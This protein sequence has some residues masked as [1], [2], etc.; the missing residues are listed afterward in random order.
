MP[1]KLCSHSYFLTPRSYQ[2]NYPLFVFLPGMD[3]TG[4]E[5]MYIQ[6][7]GLEAAFDVRCFVIPP[8]DL[9]SWDEMTDELASLTQIELKKVPRSSVYLCAE[10]F[11]CCLGIKVLERFPQLFTK[12]I[13]I[14]S[15]SS[16]HRVP[17]L[18]LG[19]RLF[20]YTPN[21]FYKISSFISL[22]CLA[23]LNR[24]SPAAKKALLNS[25]R[26]APKATA[27]QRLTLMREFEM[28]EMKLTQITQP[29]LLIAS[30]ND[31]LLPSEA[32]AIRL[33]NIFPNFQ[34]IN[35]PHSGHACLVEKDVNIYQI[36]MSV[37][38]IFM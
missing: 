37:N 1:S 21:F 18:N 36:L 3:E 25:T 30:K 19:S 17:W 13:L 26:S 34:I 20:P 22:P 29:V 15:A 5:L 32:E 14:N 31:R 11:G 33:S 9:T 7:A 6:T 10:S 35:L 28:N 38:F 24:I 4:K 23:N 12:I 16:F 2:P 8:D 27:S